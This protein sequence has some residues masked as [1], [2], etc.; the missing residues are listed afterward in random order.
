MNRFTG[1]TVLITGGT[2]GMGLATAHRLLAEGAHV[3]VTGRTRDRVD[4]AVAA[5]G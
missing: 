5:L 2:S 4:A 3:V 1:R